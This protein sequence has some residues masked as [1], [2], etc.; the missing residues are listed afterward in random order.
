M[1]DVCMAYVRVMQRKHAV[2]MQAYF[3]HWGW[4]SAAPA[5]AAHTVLAQGLHSAYKWS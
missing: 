4:V 5:P 3:K 2:C 1:H